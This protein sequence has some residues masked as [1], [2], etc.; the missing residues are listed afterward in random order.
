MVPTTTQKINKN[1]A[2]HWI[3]RRSFIVPCNYKGKL[4]FSFRQSVS[5]RKTD[6]LSSLKVNVFCFGR[7]FRLAWA[8][9]FYFRGVFFF[10]FL[11]G[12][13]FLAYL[14]WEY[15]VVLKRTE[16]LVFVGSLFTPWKWTVV[17]Y[18]VPLVKLHAI[19]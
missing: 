4:I 11:G 13:S 5:Y 18:L 9:F 16:F 3:S 19:R 8:H 1:Q 15:L 14:L 17:E 6:K 2:K 12:F 10:F 7:L